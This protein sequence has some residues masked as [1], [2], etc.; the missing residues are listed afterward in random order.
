MG[1]ERLVAPR[2]DGDARGGYSKGR[3]RRGVDPLAR[4]LYRERVM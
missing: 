2:S 4:A 3:G 1:S